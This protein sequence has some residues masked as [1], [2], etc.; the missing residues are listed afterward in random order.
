VRER[1]PALGRV[2]V[3]LEAPPLHFHIELVLQP[4][5][6]ALLRDEAEGSNEVG[7]QL[8]AHAHG[9]LLGS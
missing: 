4:D 9:C 8:D 6:A 5:Q 7:V 3:Q 2:R 1:H